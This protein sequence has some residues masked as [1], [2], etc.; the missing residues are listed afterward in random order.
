[1]IEDMDAV[2]AGQLLQKHFC[3]GVIDASHLLVVVEIADAADVLHQ[4]ETFLVKCEINQHPARI[5][6]WYLMRVIDDG[7]TWRTSWGTEG[8]GAGSFARRCEVIQLRLDPWQAF[9]GNAL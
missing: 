3:F 6:D 5:N 7:R 2:R 8:I 4:A 9:G 1:M